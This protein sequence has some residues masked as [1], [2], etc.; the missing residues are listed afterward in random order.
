[1]T[2]NNAMMSSEAHDWQTPDNV[3]GLV[4]ELGAIRLDPC[5]VDE[6][7]VGATVIIAPPDDGLALPWDG[8]WTGLVFVNPPYGTA[9]RKWV[10]KACTE[11]ELGNE[12]VMLVPGRIDTGWYST[13]RDSAN[14]LCEWRGRL[15]FRGAPTSAPFPSALFYWGD[16]PF[17]FAHVFQAAGNVSVLRQRRRT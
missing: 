6:N 7:P 9:L 2:I 16:R 17:L 14:A 4:R 12:V 13:A 1:M 11:G 5:T 3:L 10:E 15:R 8:E